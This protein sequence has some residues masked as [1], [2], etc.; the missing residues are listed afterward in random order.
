MPRPTFH[1]H[2]HLYLS[3]ELSISLICPSL[4]RAVSCAAFSDTCASASRCLAVS[5]C[6]VSK[7]RSEAATS[8]RACNSEVRVLC[9]VAMHGRI[10]T[11]HRRIHAPRTQLSPG[12]HE[13]SMHAWLVAARAGSDPPGIPAG[14]IRAL[15]CTSFICASQG[16]SSAL[17]P[18]SCAR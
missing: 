13:H 1:R 3:T 11:S 16:A 12:E 6:F 9:Q 2:T 8:M 7:S 5:C 17:T 10:C 18:S 14:H 4:L 15:T